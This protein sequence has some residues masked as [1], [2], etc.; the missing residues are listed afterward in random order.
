M[1][2]C[3]LFDDILDAERPTDAGSSPR[4]VMRLRSCRASR[5]MNDTAPEDKAAELRAT[6]TTHYRSSVIA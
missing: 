1:V 3:V 5:V 4:Q 6:S 2:W